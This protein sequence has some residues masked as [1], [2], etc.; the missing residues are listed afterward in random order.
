MCETLKYL[1]RPHAPHHKQQVPQ[2]GERR[3]MGTRRYSLTWAAMSTSWGSFKKRPSPS[4][5][6]SSKLPESRKRREARSKGQ[7]LI[8]RTVY[9]R[10]L[11]FIVI[12]QQHPVNVTLRNRKCLNDLY[13]GVTL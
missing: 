8:V 7:E 13:V 12:N 2:L 1:Y 5:R 9:P 10:L 11:Y 4:F 3:P 6:K